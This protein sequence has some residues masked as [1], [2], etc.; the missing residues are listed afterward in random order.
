MAETRPRQHQNNTETSPKKTETRPRHDRDITET[1]P[2]HPG[3]I[4]FPVHARRPAAFIHV[5]P[6]AYRIRN[7]YLKLG[8][9]TR[10]KQWYSSHA[11]PPS[12]R[13]RSCSQAKLFGDF[14]GAGSATLA[15]S[16][17]QRFNE[18][19]PG[20]SVEF[21]FGCHMTTTFVLQLLKVTFS[22]PILELP[23]NT[24]VLTRYQAME[25]ETIQTVAYEAPL[26]RDLQFFFAQG[27][28]SSLL[29]SFCRI[30]PTPTPFFSKSRSLS[31]VFGWESSGNRF[32]MF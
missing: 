16:N 12:Q 13:W 22:Y 4:F 28:P 30:I 19:P 24:D 14:S 27:F 25:W 3:W 29:R 15:Q 7:P 5:R 18:W 26:V 2:R 11:L 32:K 23:Q 8:W 17:V 6:Q 9:P 1:R 10:Q 21:F 31:K 20:I